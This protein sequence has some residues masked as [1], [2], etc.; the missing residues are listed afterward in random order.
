[1]S[2]LRFRGEAAVL[3]LFLAQAFSRGRIVGAS[4]TTWGLV[5]W[6]AASIGLAALMFSNASQ[7]GAVLAAVG[8]LLNINVV[9]VNG[10]MPVVT[11]AD[12]HTTAVSVSAASGG[13]Y[14]LAHLG[15]VAVWAGDAIRL[16]ILGQQYLLSIGDILLAVGVATIVANAMISSEGVS[17]GANI[18]GSPLH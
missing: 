14:Q 18:H 11:P 9:L 2:K 6:A 15:T 13:F 10:A 7:P 1:M 17:G 12:A 5:V 4:A 16:P 8:V 3:A